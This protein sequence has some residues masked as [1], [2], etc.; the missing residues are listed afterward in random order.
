MNKVILP[1]SIV[2]VVFDF[3]SRHDYR[4]TIVLDIQEVNAR[5]YEVD[6][7]CDSSLITLYISQGERSCCIIDKKTRE[8][9]DFIY[10]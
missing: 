5:Q 7:E 10:Y 4:T 8:R 6:L 2:D 3:A 1:Q 9:S